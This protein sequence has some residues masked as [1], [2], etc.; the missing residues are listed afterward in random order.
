MLVLTDLL[1]S[2]TLQVSCDLLEDDS[3][4]VISGT[5]T[6]IPAGSSLFKIS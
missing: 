2:M 4:N 1:D 6:I 5:T 3:G